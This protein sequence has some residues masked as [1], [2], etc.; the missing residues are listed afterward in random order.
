M[1]SYL[2]RAYLS[3]KRAVSRMILTS[4]SFGAAGMSAYGY[5]EFG[6]DLYDPEA[7]QYRGKRYSR[8]GERQP[9]GYTGYRHD[10]IS[11]TYFA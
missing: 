3:P 2:E 8:R 1:A 4:C 5:D 6:V 11:G 7:E 9:F 10:D